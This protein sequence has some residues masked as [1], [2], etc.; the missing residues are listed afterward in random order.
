MTHRTFVHA[1][2]L[3]LLA[4]QCGQA[5]AAERAATLPGAG[6]A[7]ETPCAAEVT[8]Q[9]DPSLQGHA[10][11]TASADHQEELDR[12]VFDTQGDARIS[13][14]R[15]DCWRPAR[16]FS[17]RPTLKLTVQVSPGAPLSIAEDGFGRY[18][19]G[20]IGGPFTVAIAGAAE[21]RAGRIT[22]L[23]AD[24]NGTGGLTVA[25]L[26]GAVSVSISGQGAI[27]IAQASAPTLSVD[28]SGAGSFV[29][30]NGSIGKATLDDSGAGSIKLGTTV[31]DV[32]A[33]LSGIGSVHLAQV[34][35]RLHKEISGVGSISIGD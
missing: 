20:D 29:I 3:A 13:T 22:T 2:L 31:G 24:I 18:T 19:V 12:L 11:V 15:Q 8:I 28:L 7:I 9:P 26:D 23:K 34:L 6:L 21:V 27:S 30:K 4:A 32:T 33:N 17:F 35:G 1:G 25:A 16:S 10:I 5:L 14:G